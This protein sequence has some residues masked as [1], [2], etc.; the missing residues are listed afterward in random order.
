MNFYRTEK[1]D[2]AFLADNMMGP[3]SLKILEELVENVPLKK[4]MRV[5][6]LGCG[7]GLTSIFLARE[8]GVQVFA[9]DLWVSATDNYQRFQEMGV[10]DAV[11]PLHADALEMP[12][13]EGYFDAVLSVD[14]YHYVGNNDTFFPEKVRPVLKRNGLVALAFPGLK[15]EVQGHIPAEMTPYWEEEALA[16]WHAQS[17][18]Q[19]KFE[20]ELTHLQIWEL[21]C[22][23]EAWQDWLRTDN[24]YALGDRAMLRADG[25]RYMNLIGITGVLR[26]R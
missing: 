18:W 13:A 11:I 14:A 23:E 1:Y 10:D 26:K 21:A 16:T 24:P 8:Y 15:N 6:D 9:L 19:P 20:R 4:G 25:G 3:N 12:F 17:W 5:L 2:Q 7:K 22:F